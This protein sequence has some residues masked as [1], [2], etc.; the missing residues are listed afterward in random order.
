MNASQD[1]PS[2]KALS[3]YN[4]LVVKKTN[5]FPLT[6][7][8]ALLQKNHL[9]AYDAEDVQQGVDFLVERGLAKVEGG[10]LVATHSRGP[11]KPVRLKRKPGRAP[12]G[13]RDPDADLQLD[14]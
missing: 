6:R 2:T 8:I 1:W 10:A 14:P 11:G 9:P 4:V 3:V 5:A 7:V 12:D 13:T